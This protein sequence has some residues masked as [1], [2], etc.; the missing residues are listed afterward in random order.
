MI[1]LEQ[2]ANDGADLGAGPDFACIDHPFPRGSIF[3]A[4]LRTVHSDYCPADCRDDCVSEA[5]SGLRSLRIG[6]AIIYGPHT[7]QGFYDSIFLPESEQK[8][9]LT[10]GQQTACRL[11]ARLLAALLKGSGRAFKIKSWKDFDGLEACVSVDVDTYGGTPRQKL[12]GVLLPGDP[13]IQKLAQDGEILGTDPVPAPA[14]AQGGTPWPGQSSPAPAAAP[15]QGGT[16]WGGQ[17][18]QPAQA[19]QLAQNVLGAV[20]QYAPPAAPANAWGPGAED[21]K[22]PF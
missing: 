12:A 9:Q 6:V 17:P 2:Y 4:R 16:P 20:P 13:L 15:A 5:K 8:I 19:V 3:R 7:G 11:G 14:P 22:L 21:D 18:A 10:R 1:D